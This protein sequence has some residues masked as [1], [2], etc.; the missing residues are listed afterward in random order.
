MLAMMLVIMRAM[1]ERI[2]V[3]MMIPRVA[4]MYRLLEVFLK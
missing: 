3:M 4:M 2:L 1:M